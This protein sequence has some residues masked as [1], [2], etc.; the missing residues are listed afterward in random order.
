MA[1]GDVTVSSATINSFWGAEFDGINDFLNSSLS[2]NG[3]TKATLIATFRKRITTNQMMIVEDNNDLG[4]RFEVLFFTDNK[5]YGLVGTANNADY[6]Y[7]SAL[8]AE[9]A[10]N[11]H[12]IA[13]VYDG[14]GATNADKLKIYIDGIEKSL[15]FVGNIATSCAASG[16]IK[17]GKRGNGVTWTTGIVG[18]AV[19]YDE[20][21]SPTEISQDF[22]GKRSTKNLIAKWDLRD[23]YDDSSGNGK[24]F[25]NNGTHR[26]VEESSVRTAIT[27]LRSTA[28]SS[29][30]YL[31]IKGKMGQITGVGIE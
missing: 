10:L 25:T 16:G 26:A 29:A 14:S 11:P 7:T 6:G 9:D 31:I 24:N 17:I 23:D 8:T 19:V 12:R 1:A 18:K 15:T 3:K 27:T 30:K 4:D 13:L 21:L 2:M 20:C 5:I 22:A 28:G